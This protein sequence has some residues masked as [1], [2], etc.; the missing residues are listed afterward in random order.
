M[1]LSMYNIHLVTAIQGH[2]CYKL[3]TLRSKALSCATGSSSWKPIE[4]S[5]L[6]RSEDW[7]RSVRRY[8]Q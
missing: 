4:R 8:R 7:T 6:H 2:C 1:F 3:S 5:A